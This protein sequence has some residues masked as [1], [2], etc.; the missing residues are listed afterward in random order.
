[1]INRTTIYETA[2][3]YLGVPHLHQGR[4]PELG[5]DCIGLVLRTC[6]DLGLG[7]HDLAAYS[8][9]PDGTTLVTQFDL[10]VPERGWT[11]L[12][13]TLGF[14]PEQR[15]DP[16]PGDIVMFWIRRRERPTHLGIVGWKN[17]RRT[18]I[19]SDRRFGA[20]V[21]HSVNDWWLERCMK[22]YNPPGLEPWHP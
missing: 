4:H 7:H 9:N 14:H 12:P 6:D 13:D 1:M 17:G 15:V 3:R 8:R 22:I 20:A 21:E 11:C 5:L 2:R 19:H 18:I 10:L 16:S